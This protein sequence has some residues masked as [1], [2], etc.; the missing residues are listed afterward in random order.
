[1][2][3]IIQEDL[4]MICPRCKIQLRIKN[5]CTETRDEAAVTVQELHCVNPQCPL[6][7]DA[8]PVK[9]LEH[10]HEQR[11]DDC[12]FERCSG[13]GIILM[14]SN[15][16]S[17]SVSGKFTLDGGGLTINCPNCEQENRFYVDGKTPLP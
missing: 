12:T 15:D 7:S 2:Q 11:R 8:V 14:K 6:K 1:M 16:R 10:R 13:C 4:N 17:Y 5:S 3:V 9:I